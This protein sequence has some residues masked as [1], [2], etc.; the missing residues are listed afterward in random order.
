MRDNHVASPHG[1]AQWPSGPACARRGPGHRC[2]APTSEARGSAISPSAAAASLRRLL[3]SEPS[4][5]PETSTQLRPDPTERIRHLG[6]CCPDRSV[7]GCDR[8]CQW[9]RAGEPCRSRPLPARAPASSRLPGPPG[10]S[11]RPV[12]ADEEH[13]SRHGG[14]PH[15]RVRIARGPH[16]RRQRGAASR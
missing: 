6:A 15:A 13:E 11:A 8:A 5:L 14:A 2:N 3:T 9:L 10:G 4:G 1:T 7:I 16:Q 12:H